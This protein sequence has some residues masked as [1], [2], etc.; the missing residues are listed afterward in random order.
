MKSTVF[1][2]I[3]ILALEVSAAKSSNIPGMA[4]RILQAQQSIKEKRHQCHDSNS[5][6]KLEENKTSTVNTDYFNAQ[7]TCE[8]QCRNNKTVSESIKDVFEPKKL[9][10][11]EGDGSSNEKIMWRSLGITLSTWSQELCLNK[12]QKK[13]SSLK[14]VEK[15]SVKKIKSGNW[16]F[17]GKLKC[18]SSK[19]VYSPF[20][21]QFKLDN[22]GLSAYN[23][24]EMKFNQFESKT[25]KT[26][27][28]LSEYIGSRYTEKE[29]EKWIDA[30]SCS[31]AIKVKACF[32]DCVWEEGA[33]KNWR[34]TL[35][36]SEPLGTDEYSICVDKILTK[37][38][39]KGLS[40]EVVQVKCEK[41]AWELI[42]KLEFS[43]ASC[44]ATRADYDCSALV[45]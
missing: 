8:F 18:S 11:Y 29:V 34:E 38:S 42:R 36:T 37:N 2:F 13:C 7:I 44:A 32:G 26:V 25:I 27:N 16:S 5:L 45:D 33:D 10:L 1:L 19:T 31:K 28:N 20:D 4:T 6:P 17:D 41:I 22:Q 15:I 21:S 12:A 24:F 39:F 30:K 9:S 14:N 23:P 35:S 43:G 40:K 3:I